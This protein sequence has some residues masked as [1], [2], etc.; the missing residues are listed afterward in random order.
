VDYLSSAGLGALKAGVA[1]V[2]AAGAALAVTGLEEPVRLALEL[3]GIL[4]ALRIEPTRDA[5]I[6]RLQDG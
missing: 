4:D 3:D 2:A 6:A 1:A 5:A